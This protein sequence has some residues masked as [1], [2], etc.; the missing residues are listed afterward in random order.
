MSEVAELP[1][2]HL[3]IR[4]PDGPRVPP[5]LL[6]VGFMLSRRRAFLWLRRRYGASA[7][8]RIPVIGSGVVV[9]DPALVKRVFQT[10]PDVLGY[11]EPNL[12][13]VL[14][15]GSTFALEGDEHRARRK[16]L[17]PPFHGKR[18]RAYESIVEEETLREAATWPLGEEFATLQPFMRITLNVILRAVFGAEGREIEELREILPRLVALGSRLAIVPPIA[19]KNLGRFSPWGRLVYERRRYDAVVG[20]LIDAALDDPDLEQ[21]QDVLAMLLVARYE[22]GSALTR[23]HIAD[24]LLTLLAAGHETTATT[25]AWAIE[26]LRRHPQLW[27]RLVAEADDDGFELREATVLEVQ[28]TRP[29]IEGTSR[30]VVADRVDLGDW[31]IPRGYQV[32]V[33][34]A[35]VHA[36]EAIWPNADV[37][38]PDRF[39]GAPPDNYAWIPF[40]G[41]TRRCVGAAFATMEMNVVLRTLLKNYQLTPT[42]AADE[43]WHSRGIAFAPAKGGLA[44]V[45][46][47][48]LRTATTPATARETVSK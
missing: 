40:G 5:W 32:M 27:R 11:G 37:F 17:V 45:H 39:V 7:T 48:P 46:P 29:V 14:G 8:V 47:R 9:S 22:D 6:G 12:G 35:A 24:E 41:G 42:A 38:D 25:L 10:S 19:R 13:V 31:V 33:S 28:R 4:L 36:D 20:R 18:M 3:A 30:R 43:R 15:D 21:R 1:S 23:G 16:I 44:V 26:R 2:S 34:I